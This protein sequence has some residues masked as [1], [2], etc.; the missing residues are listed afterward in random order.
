MSI[1]NICIIA[2]L[3]RDSYSI[4]IVLYS[5]RMEEFWL[6]LIGKYLNICVTLVNIE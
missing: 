1:L 3:I 5:Q 6:D 4:S 2:I